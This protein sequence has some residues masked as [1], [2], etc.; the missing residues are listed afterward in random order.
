MEKPMSSHKSDHG[1]G[2]GGASVPPSG[3][4]G[5]EEAGGESAPLWVISFADLSTLL[6]SFFVLMMASTPKGQTS[7]SPDAELLKVIASI[8]ASFRYRPVPGSKDPLDMAVMK[9]LSA[10]EKTSGDPESGK[11]YK[12]AGL[13]GTSPSVSDLFNKS[14]STVGEPIPFARNSAEISREWRWMIEVVA[15][16]VREH[17]RIIIIRGH[18]SPDEALDEPDGGFDLAYRRAVAIKQ[19]LVENGIASARFRLLSCGAQ[20]PAEYD[21]Q[22]VTPLDRDPEAIHRRSEICLG[23]SFV[24]D[25]LSFGQGESHEAPGGH[26]GG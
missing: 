24:P 12:G 3:G 14:A 10:R 7:N 4:G 1:A 22:E 11:W 23:A 9:V 21:S 25:S 16:V 19:A 6:M 18:V 26:T 15:E 17:Y 5:H 20:E 8:K 13:K 2:G